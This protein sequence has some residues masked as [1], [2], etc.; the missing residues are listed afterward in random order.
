[1][2][3]TNK[4]FYQ[5]KVF[6]FN[7]LFVV[8]AIASL[9]GFTE[10]E[11]GEDVSEIAA[12]AIAA[13]QPDHAVQHPPGHPLE[14]ARPPSPRFLSLVV[15]RVPASASLPQHPSPSVIA[16]RMRTSIR[17]SN[18]PR[19]RATNMSNKKGITR[20]KECYCHTCRKWFHYLGINRHHAMHRDKREN[21]KIT[22]ASGITKSWKF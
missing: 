14:K 12:V 18:L 10:Y 21:H 2:N 5:S 19:K 17:R 4:P 11:P 3:E 13:D 8:I 1:M 20:A 6:W 15:G 22:Y 16:R 7:M 9:F